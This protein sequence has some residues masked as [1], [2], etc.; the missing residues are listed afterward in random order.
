MNASEYWILEAAVEAWWPL[1]IVAH[2]DHS[3]T[4]NRKNHG[5][6]FEQLF[7]VFRGLFDLSYLIGERWLT[8]EIQNEDTN[9]PSDT[10][11][12]VPNDDELLVGLRGVKRIDYR[13]TVNGGAAWEAASKPN[14]NQYVAS[15]G[16]GKYASR[17]RDILEEYARMTR[18]WPSA[19][20]VDYRIEEQRPFQATYW[21]TFS[22]GYLLE[23]IPPENETRFD[24]DRG[25]DSQWREWFTRVRSGWY[26]NPFE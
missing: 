16:T 4:M 8:G 17:N 5:M 23:F 12:F 11:F 25:E 24:P 10:E 14:W 21:K 20:H 1:W 13:L 6:S 22:V 18:G 15:L 19:E 26:T 9:E 3:A 7:T 2:W